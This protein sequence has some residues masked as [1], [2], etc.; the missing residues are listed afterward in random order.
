MKVHARVGLMLT[1]QL[2]AIVSWFSLESARA[3]QGRARGYAARQ[4]FRPTAQCV[5][6][7]PIAQPRHTGAVDSRLS[8]LCN[9]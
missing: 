7:G 2:P 3:P 9:G 8:H 6:G 1:I 5:V 4:I